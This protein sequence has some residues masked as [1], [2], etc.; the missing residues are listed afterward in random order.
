MLEILEKVLV[1]V[2]IPLLPLL[3]RYIIIWIQAQIDKLATS[4]DLEKLEQLKFY[5]D[6][7]KETIEEVVLS[8]NQTYVDMLKEGKLFDDDAQKM[9][10]EKSKENVLSLISEQ[11][12]VAIEQLHGD[13]LVFINTLIEATVKRMKP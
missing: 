6:I 8:V 1:V 5:V 4:K 10:F 9:A 3:T 13:Y 12:K 7:V 11:G 2:L